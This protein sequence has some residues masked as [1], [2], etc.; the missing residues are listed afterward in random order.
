M[1][2]IYYLSNIEIKAGD[3]IKYH[4]DPGEIEFVVTKPIGDQALDWFLEDHP[5][6][7]VMITAKVWG[8]VFLSAQGIPD[9]E[10]LEFVSRAPESST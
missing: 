1:P 4:D 6:G 10:D 9:D 7:G 3:R 5:D 2:I 8:T